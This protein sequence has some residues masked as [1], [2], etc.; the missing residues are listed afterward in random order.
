MRRPFFA[1]CLYASESPVPGGRLES[2]NSI[3]WSRWVCL[4]AVAGNTANAS[5][6]IKSKAMEARLRR[7]SAKRGSSSRC[8][9]RTGHHVKGVFT[10]SCA[11]FRMTAYKLCVCFHLTYPTAP[12]WEIKGVQSTPWDLLK[13]SRPVRKELLWQWLPHCAI[14]K[15]F[16]ERERHVC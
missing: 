2:Y 5:Q 16:S 10:F 13:R 14:T 1:L 9:S 8:L 3:D 4:T 15:G 12:S 6:G 7:C 11:F